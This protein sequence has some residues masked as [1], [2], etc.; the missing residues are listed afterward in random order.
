VGEL[1]L[2]LGGDVAG[3]WRAGGQLHFGRE[4]TAN[5]VGVRLRQ[6]YSGSAGIA[7]SFYSGRLALGLEAALE[8]N[9]KEGNRLD[10]DSGAWFLG[11]AV[12]WRLSQWLVMDFAIQGGTRYASDD[13]YSTLAVGRC[14]LVLGVDF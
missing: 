3:R 5:L 2:V 6:F 1:G 4:I 14:N 10:F 11:P 12:H 9:D 7:Y 13:E 8:A